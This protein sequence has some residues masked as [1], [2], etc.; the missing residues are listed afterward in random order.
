MAKEAKAQNSVADSSYYLAKLFE[1]KGEKEKAIMFYQSY[2]EA[3]KSEKPDKKDRKLVDKARVAY[4]IAK[5][6]KNM[7]RYIGIMCEKD[8]LKA[9]LD[10]K[11]KRVLK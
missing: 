1:E 11:I 3:A 7:D 6:N 9:L 8:S 5:S 2:F 4:A 10:W